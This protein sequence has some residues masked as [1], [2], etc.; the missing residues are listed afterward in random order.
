MGLYDIDVI[1]EFDDDVDTLLANGFT[2][3]KIFPPKYYGTSEIAAAKVAVLSA[4]AK[5]AE[6]VWGYCAGPNTLTS[7]NWLDYRQGIL[8]AAQW[9]QDNGVYEFRLGNEDLA[10]NDDTTLTD[11]QLI[12]NFKS[13]ATEVQ[14][15]FTNGNVSYACRSDFIDDWITA[16]KGDIDILA[17]NVYMGG[18]AKLVFFR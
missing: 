17:S 6:V 9:S 18:W 2:Q 8:D 16:G 3:L 1:S 10:H 14:A 4:I 5:G 12:I 7:T 15:I 13:V 11:A